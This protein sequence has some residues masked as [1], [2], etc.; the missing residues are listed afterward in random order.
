M[1]K[2]G[3]NFGMNIA[4]PLPSQTLQFLA[5]DTSELQAFFTSMKHKRVDRIVVVIPNVKTSYGKR[6]IV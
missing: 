6:C 2:I 1:R 3:K 4:L 5:K